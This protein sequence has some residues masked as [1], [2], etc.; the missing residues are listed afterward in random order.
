[1]HL[2][3]VGWLPHCLPTHR[4]RIRK[5]CLPSQENRDKDP[6]IGRVFVLSLFPTLNLRNRG[7]NRFEKAILTKASKETRVIFN[8][9]NTVNHSNSRHSCNVLIP[10]FPVPRV[11]R[12]YSPPA[13]ADY[14]PRTNTPSAE[15]KITLS[16][17]RIMRTETTVDL[18]RRPKVPATT[19]AALLA[20]LNA[21]TS[22]LSTNSP[23]CS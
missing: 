3:R 18:P 23:P 19:Q 16:E 10:P 15:D 12:K 9:L 8:I 5:L 2:R 13:L 17:A 21:L 4:R 11:Q 20:L 1:M 22:R 6:V 14:R 7:I